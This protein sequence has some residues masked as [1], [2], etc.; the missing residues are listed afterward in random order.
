MR[1]PLERTI[2]WAPRV[3]AILFAIFIS[4]FALDV[5]TEGYSFGET[6]VALAMHLIPTAILVIALAI[7][8]RWERT[9][10]ILHLALAAL[11]LLLF[12]QRIE[13]YGALIVVVPLLLIGTLFLACGVYQAQQHARA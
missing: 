6:L 11:Y 8:W 9:G 1:S 4:L 2:Y 5:F 13:D 10:G 3:T 7:A 12:W